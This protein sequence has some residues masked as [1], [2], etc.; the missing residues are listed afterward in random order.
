MLVLLEAD[1][2]LLDGGIW[3]MDEEASE[4]FELK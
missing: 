4:P 3:R 2:I 1:L